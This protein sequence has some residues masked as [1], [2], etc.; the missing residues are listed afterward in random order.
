MGGWNKKKKKKADT[1]K[2]VNKTKEGN[3]ITL[4]CK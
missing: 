4:P 2:F 3:E 1:N